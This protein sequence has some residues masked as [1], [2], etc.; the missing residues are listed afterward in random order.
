MKLLATLDAETNEI[1]VPASLDIVK[2]SPHYTMVGQYVPQEIPM[3]LSCLHLPSQ[4]G[5]KIMRPC[6]QVIALVAATG[7]GKLEAAGSEGYK[8]VNN[9]VRDL[10]EKSGQTFEVTS[11]CSLAN[12]QDFKLDPPKRANEQAALV[13]LSDA[14]PSG[15][16]AVLNRF[17][18]ESVQLLSPS[19]AEKIL[20]VFKQ[21]IYFASLATQIAQG[22]KRKVEWTEDDNPGT[23]KK[24]KTLGRSPTGNELPQ[25]STPS[26]AKRLEIST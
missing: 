26:P 2:H 5:S 18:L 25:Y 11:Y 4:S 6:S 12:L 3:E 1:I 19:E 9:T 8:V 21:F 23:A 13:V 16:D 20:P 24:C 14:L 17:V 22:E 10:T 15:R 7:P